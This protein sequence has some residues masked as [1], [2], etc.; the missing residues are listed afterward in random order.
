MKKTN[1]PKPIQTGWYL[2]FIAWTVVTIATLG[3]LFFSEVMDVPVCKLCWY[4]RIT[5]YPMVLILVVGLFP[6]DPRVVRTVAPMAAIG[7]LIALYQVLLIA[8][9]IPKSMQPCVQGIPC[10][11]SHLSLLGF[12]NIPM[13]SLITFSLIGI[14]LIF[15]RKMELL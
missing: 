4:Q 15:T 3:S 2:I 8:G 14:L 5:M 6:F 9:I 7:W 11:E 1:S 13:L 12:L 10:S